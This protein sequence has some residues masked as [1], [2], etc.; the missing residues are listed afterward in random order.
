MGWTTRRWQAYSQDW[1]KWG[2]GKGREERKICWSCM[3]FSYTC[4]VH[5]LC[6]F[7]C[8]YKYHGNSISTEYYYVIMNP[9]TRSSY[10][11]RG[12]LSSYIMSSYSI[13]QSFTFL[14]SL[15]PLFPFPLLTVFYL[16]SPLLPLPL[17]LLLL[18]LLI[19]IIIIFIILPLLL[20]PS[21]SCPP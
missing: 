10:R 19:T 8:H 13:F 3:C 21:I 9:V 17:P 15:L 11:S 16:L 18:F 1:C 12:V 7:Y 14:P 20:L 6:Y 4:T 5:L 2:H